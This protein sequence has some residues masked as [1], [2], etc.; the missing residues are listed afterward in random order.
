MCGIFAYC[1]PKYT[2]LTG[3]S[4][5]HRGPDEKTIKTY[6]KE[7]FHCHMEFHRLKINGLS[8]DS[9]QPF[10]IDNVSL[11]ANGEIYNFKKLAEVYNLNLK[12][13]SDCEVIIHLYNL[14][15][16]KK[17]CELL[18]GEFAFCIF[19][20]NT[21]EIHLARDH[22]GIR[23]LYYL[24]DEE[25]TFAV[26]SELKGLMNF[27]QCS[28]DLT[29]ERGRT[30]P[31]DQFPNASYGTYNINSKKFVIFNYKTF[32][33]TW[34]IEPADEPWPSQEFICKNIS[35]IIKKSVGKRLMC[36]R[37]MPDGS[38]AIGAFLS[39]GF[40]S[41][42][43]A[44]LAQSALK[45]KLHTFSI[46]FL[47]SPDLIAAREVSQYI[48]SEHHEY[49]VE[50]EFMLDLIP[51]VIQQIETYDITTVRASTFMYA[52]SKFIKRDFPEIVV[53]LSG[54]GADE[55]SG[56]YL[57][58]R[59]LILMKYGSLDYPYWTERVQDEFSEETMR[60]LNDLRYFDALRGD[61]TTAA[62]SLEIR[63]PFLD[64][65]FLNYYM[66]SFK[67]PVN[68]KLKNSIEKYILREAMTFKYIKDSQ[69]RQLLPDHIIW[70][71]KEAMSDGV[72]LH[73]ESWFQ[74]IQTRLMSQRRKTFAQPFDVSEPVK[75]I[76]LERSWYKELYTG[77]YPGCSHLLPYYWL[78]RWTYDEDSQPVQDPSA[79][80]LNCYK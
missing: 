69:G 12:G 29:I 10:N 41:S 30:A 4:I 67:V 56:S 26:S 60:L 75:G 17:T 72:S 7:S 11:L 38:V 8:K 78:P 65:D 68:L 45:S 19:D 66:N 2:G 14:V 33:N 21:N 27:T 71:T 3:S 51:E 35:E 62:H 34:N 52:L 42:I 25:G 13:H 57:Y 23:S 1:S 77:Y 37:Q 39:G 32:L 48:S 28:T 6:S 40:D 22:V 79:R 43:V 20:F 53:I 15:G 16:I 49:V 59:N 76:D 50:K 63:V 31:V 24:H 46:G 74:I 64:Q 80:I 61:K 54:E 58:F 55:A 70:R 5:K 47:N 18:N 44:A 36:D 73:N 9:S